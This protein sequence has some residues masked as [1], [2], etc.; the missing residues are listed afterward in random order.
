[1]LGI[2]QPKDMTGEDLRMPLAGHEKL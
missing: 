2:P 1:M